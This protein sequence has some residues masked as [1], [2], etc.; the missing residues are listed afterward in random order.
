MRALVSVSASPVG[1]R[2]HWVHDDVLKDV[3]RDNGNVQDGNV[4]DGNVQGGN[5]Q[6]GNVPRQAR[7]MLANL[8]CLENMQ[9]EL[10]RQCSR[11]TRATGARP[12]LRRCVSPLVLHD[13]CTVVAGCLRGCSWFE[14]HP[15]A[16]CGSNTWGRSCTPPS[17]TSSGR[18]RRLCSDNLVTFCWMCLARGDSAGSGDRAAVT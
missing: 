9:Q 1:A 17:W 16:R 6:D 12:W 15:C 10:E 3:L 11:I 18:L 13:A 7:D 8:A 4:Q 5:V 14:S 2:L